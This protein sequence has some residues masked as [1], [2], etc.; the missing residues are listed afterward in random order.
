MTAFLAAKCDAGNVDGTC[1][2]IV[3]SD[4][5]TLETLA[6]RLRAL[7]WLIE[8]DGRTYCDRHARTRTL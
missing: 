7:G 3:Y 6:T 2:A 8:A 4:R 1:P 5:L